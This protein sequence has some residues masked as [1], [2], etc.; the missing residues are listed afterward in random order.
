MLPDQHANTPPPATFL[1]AVRLVSV[2]P[3]LGKQRALGAGLRRHRMVT[4]RERHA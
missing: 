4:G 3:P 1:P 2:H